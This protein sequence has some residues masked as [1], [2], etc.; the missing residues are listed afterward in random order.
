[1]Y[2]PPSA[3]AG[4]RGVEECP[5]R[6]VLQRVASA[7]VTVAGAVVGRI[8]TGLVAL[9]GVARDDTPDR[10]IRLAQKTARLRVLRA[11]DADFERSL[12]D[13]GAGLLCV[14][15]FTLLADVRRGTRPSWSGAAD[16]A[17]AEP[18]V[19]AYGE[20]LESLGVPVAYGRFGALMVVSFVAD[21][22]VT[23]VLDSADLEAPRG[24]GRRL[25]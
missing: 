24:G 21:G 13:G 18:I 4:L 25:D 5:V 22:P 11:P 8:E 19:R 16:G 17:T 20:H 12:L 6:V 10:A 15:Q 3:A 2:E 1:M 9:V 23:I 7:S 14:S